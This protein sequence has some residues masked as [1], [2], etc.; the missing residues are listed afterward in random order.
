MSSITSNS[1]RSS[2][3]EVFYLKRILK[4]FAAFTGKNRCRI[5]FFNEVAGPRPATSLKKR[6][7][8]RCF[9]MKFAK[10]LKRPFLQ[11]TAGF[12]FFSF[13]SF[14]K[15]VCITVMVTTLLLLDW[16]RVNSK[17]KCNINYFFYSCFFLKRRDLYIN[18]ISKTVK[19]L[20]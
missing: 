11:N 20:S 1:S 6:L 17:N 15:G 4:N 9:L 3:P 14:T 8:Q 13:Q 2:H 16:I 10:F 18:T 12:S 7:R 5:L 19:E